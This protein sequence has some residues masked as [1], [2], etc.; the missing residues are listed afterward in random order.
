M[1]KVLFIGILLS[2]YVVLIAPL[3]ALASVITGALYSGVI[4]VSN[5]GSTPANNVSVPFV[6]NTQVM[7]DGGFINAALDDVAVQ[8]TAGADVAFMTG[9]N[10]TAP[11]V[12][13]VPQITANTFLNNILYTGN[14]TG[15]TIRYFGDDD[16]M[17]VVDDPSLDIVDNWTATAS[18]WLD[19]DN[20]TRKDYFY[21]EE[22]IR[23]FGS[24]NTSGDIIAAEI[25]WVTPTDGDGTGWTNNANAFDDNTATGATFVTT[26]GVLTDYFYYSHSSFNITEIR[27]F[28][29]TSDVA[30]IEFG[31][32]TDNV[33]WLDVFIGTP[34]FDEWVTLDTG[35]FINTQFIRFRFLPT[36]TGPITTLME[37]DYGEASHYTTATGES[38]RDGT[39]TVESGN[40]TENELHYPG[41]ST[42]RVRL[43]TNEYRGI[44]KFWLYMQFR[45]DTTHQN[46]S[47]TKYLFSQTIDASNKIQVRF[48]GSGALQLVFD[49]TTTFVTVSTTQTT[50]N[51]DQNYAFIYSVDNVSGLRLATSEGEVVTN[52]FSEPTTGGSS[53][54][55]I[56][57][58]PDNPTL[59]FIGEIHTTALGTDNLTRT[60]E[61]ELLNGIIPLDATDIY[62]AD[63][64]TGTTLTS[65]GTSANDGLVSG[66]NTWEVSQRSFYFTILVDGSLGEGVRGSANITVGTANWTIARPAAMPYM[67]YSSISVFGIESG[68]WTWEYAAT[69]TDG[70]GNGNTGF[71]TFRTLTTSENVSANLTSFRPISE[72][73]APSFVLGVTG[74]FITSPNMTANFTTVV[75]PVYPGASVIEDISATQGTPAQLPFTVLAGIGILGI[76]LT[77]SWAMRRLGTESLW[78]KGLVIVILMAV[79][80][81]LRQLDFWM[82][83]FFSIL[84]IAIIFASKQRG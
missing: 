71:P 34:T 81:A 43:D 17:I 24:G 62:Y 54:T 44:N 30:N 3:I 19:T 15:G 77:L 80:V 48:T 9:F 76:S 41:T 69:F 13:F 45:L 27:Y 50:W 64:G 72:A 20:G 29:T 68:N 12:I 83:L 65:V 7:I 73:Q 61:L 66:A 28:L 11:W 10:A 52:A 67:T 2:A 58:E 22:A 21:K 63:E 60:E 25:G 8:N 5:N 35:L 47:S 18:G 4:V 49:P 84:G 46:G 75:N 55:E 16:G 57:F 32:S 51:A 38:S 53:N 82:I 26:N 74:D 6:L 33:S 14:V 42:S 40:A 79:F 59:G 1:R 39:V 37:L 31:A 78:V 70:T 23:V 56:G 36:S